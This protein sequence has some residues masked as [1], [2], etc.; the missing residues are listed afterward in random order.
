MSSNTYV[1]CYK[2]PYTSNNSKT[3]VKS[4]NNNNSINLNN[5]NITSFTKV[6]YPNSSPKQ[7]NNNALLYKTP[8][9]N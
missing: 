1:P 3:Q 4:F 9:P 7:F 5:Y 2:T 6:G 8:T